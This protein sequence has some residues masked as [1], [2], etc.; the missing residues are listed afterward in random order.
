MF[1]KTQ[2]IVNPESNQGRTRKRWKHIKESLRSIL[3]EYKYEFTEKPLQAIEICRSAIKDGIE[4]IVGVGGDGTI[5]E[6]ANGFYEDKRIINPETV[7]GVLP[8]GTGCDFS[9]SL[10]IPKGYNNAARVIQEAPSSRM[11]VGKVSYKNHNGQEEDRYFLNITDFGIGGE[12]IENMTAGREERKASSYF[13]SLV[14]TFISYKAKKLRIKV[15]GRELPA[16]EYMIGAV[17]NGKIFGKGMKIAPNALLDDGLFDLILIK[18]MNTGEFLRNV[19]KLYKG[20]HISHPKVDQIRGRRI[21]ACSD[22]EL[23]QRV[24][25]EVDGEQVGT[26]PATF[27]LSPESILVKGYF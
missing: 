1:L 26:L 14:S 24:L 3:R 20:T 21:Q 6:I 11:D 16:E 10:K 15:D 25:I 27:E 12:V 19:L 7:L 9:R 23:N 5:N 22:E 18:R 2:V 13:K 4:L 8:S 17:S